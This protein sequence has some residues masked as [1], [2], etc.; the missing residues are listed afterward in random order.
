MVGN[1]GRLLDARRTPVMVTAVR[2]GIGAFEVEIAGFED[3][4]ARWELSLA[5]IGRFQFARDARRAPPAVAGELHAARTRFARELVVE[6]DPAAA[7]DTSRAIVA[8]EIRA[9]E[10]LAG[11]VS[12]D[13]PLAEWVARRR[14]DAR[15]AAL[16]A[17]FLDDCGVG[18][19]ETAFTASFA[20][21]PA[22][23]EVVKG[24]A[25]A[26]ARLGLCRYQ[27]E[28]PRDPAMFSGAWSDGRRS[29]H[30]V[31]RIGFV[32]ALWA[33]FGRT[34]AELYRGAA[35]E[36]QIGASPP[37]SFVSATFSRAVA[38]AHFEG[39]PTTRAAILWRQRVP[40]SRLLMTFVETEAL[41]HRFLEAEAV[42]IADPTNPAF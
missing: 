23:G 1:R 32:R 35:S 25:I 38:E 3:A 24:H 9:R 14:G 27:G 36:T 21:N 4:G 6:P 28:A 17:G 19:L 11:R 37:R 12:A 26:L 8:A 30:L 10:V 18:D 7:A 33:A 13:A 34:E 42:L 16:L 20:T 2:P 5:D 15:I 29:E 31:A 39:G 41:N 40:V 22:A